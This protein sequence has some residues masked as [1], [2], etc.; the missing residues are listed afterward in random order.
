[1]AD[2]F[3]NSKEYK[4]SEMNE[5]ERDFIYRY[6]RQK[7]KD[8]GQFVLDGASEMLYTIYPVSFEFKRW[9]EDE[10]KRDHEEF[11]EK[12]QNLFEFISPESKD[13]E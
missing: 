6:Q 3:R 8:K 9:L 7:E 11:R 13:N 4:Y 2:T 10:M 1:M 5:N 12:C